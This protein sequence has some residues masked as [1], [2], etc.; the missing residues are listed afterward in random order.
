MTEP[1]NAPTADDIVRATMAHQGAIAE[2]RARVTELTRFQ[3]AEA[4][5]ASRPDHPVEPPRR[6]WKPVPP[7]TYHR[8]AK[9]DPYNWFFDLNF[10]FQVATDIATPAARLLFG[11]SLLRGETLKWWRLLKSSPRDPGFGYD[12][13]KATLL[14]RFHTTDPFRDARVQLASLKQTKSVRAYSSG[15]RTTVLSIPDLSSAEALDRCLR[16]STLQSRCKPCSTHL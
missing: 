10:F 14:A 9:E 2:L 15:F 3:K 16:G 12:H 7:D 6:S 4:K 13:F 8:K 1:P 5:A 11:A